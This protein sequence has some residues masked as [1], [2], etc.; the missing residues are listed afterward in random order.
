MGGTPPP[1]RDRP[2]DPKRGCP[3]LP[4]LPKSVKI[5][6]KVVRMAILG[7][8]V[9]VVRPQTPQNAILAPFLQFWH[10]WPPIGR[11]R[12][13]PFLAK[14]AKMAKTGHPPCFRALF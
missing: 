11:Y 10:F 3:K 2:G 1:L 12:T 14:M 4:K 8:L 13:T 6:K 7:V 9:A 5:V